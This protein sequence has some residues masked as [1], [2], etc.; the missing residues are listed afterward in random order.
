MNSNGELRRQA[1]ELFQNN[2][3]HL[4]DDIEAMSREDAQRLLHDLRIHQIELEMQNEE[5]RR[6]H[7]ELDVS[8]A[9]YVDLYEMAPMAYFILSELGLILEA[10][11]SA[12]NLLG[13]AHGALVKEPFSRFI[14]PEDQGR[15]YLRCKQLVETGA[16]Q[17]WRQ[18][19]VPQGGRPFW[20][21]LVATVNQDAAGALTI[22]VLLNEVTERKQAND[23]RRKQDELYR[24]ILQASPDAI[25]ITDL[26]TRIRM[27]SPATLRMFGCEREEQLL[28]SLATDF[29]AP[30]DRER[31]SSN[32]ALMRQGTI[33]EPSEYRGLRLDGSTFAMEVNREFIRDPEGQPTQMLFMVRDITER[34]RVEEA[35]R[36]SEA[37]YRLLFESAGDAIFIHNENAQILAANPLAC[38]RLGY[39]HDELLSLSVGQVDSPEEARHVPERIARLQEQGQLSFETVHVHKD[40]SLIPTEVTVRRIAWDGQPVLLSICRD[41]TERKRAEQSLQQEQLFSK[42]LLASLPGIFYLYT[43]PELRLV[44]WNKQHESLFGYRAEELEGRHVTHWFATE[45]KDAV[46]NAVARGVQT[47][48]NS[49]ETLLLTKDGRR[50]PFFLTGL[51][52]EAQ[53]QSYLM[54]IGIDISER[55]QAEEA[56]QKALNDIKTL[57]G[58]VPICAWCKKIRDDSGYWNQLEVYVRD[59]SEAE[60]SHGICPECMEKMHAD[61]EQGGES[62]PGQ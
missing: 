26:E 4:P 58:I 48:Q 35:L 15:Y 45:A 34:K 19:M 1:E 22:R 3:T 28:G 16:L 52:F 47:G 13:F 31:G 11:L 46:L 55:K 23:A 32:M 36:E 6:T 8:K 25:T 9:R 12:A 24:C 20:A 29:V 18:Q 21:H 7:A 56:L 10:N 60:F 2:A 5:L 17:E 51:K 37:K 50:V 57:R 44:L 54:G 61:A 53:G 27:V 38:E 40:G 41:I 49:M 33:L 43:Y 14:L 42:S 62:N 59:H 39:S 30:E